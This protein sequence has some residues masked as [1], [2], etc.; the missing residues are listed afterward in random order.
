[1]AGVSLGQACCQLQDPC[2]VY[3][4][5]EQ[6]YTRRLLGEAVVSHQ[7]GAEKYTIDLPSLDHIKAGMQ[8]Y[9]GL[10]QAK[11][12]VLPGVPRRHVFCVNFG[13]HACFDPAPSCGP[14]VG[15]CD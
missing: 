10:C 14:I 4:L 15:G 7:I 5:L 3:C 8:H 12:G 11:G 6:A 9:G 1:M 2:E 13:E